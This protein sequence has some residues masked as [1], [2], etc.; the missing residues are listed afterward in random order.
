M[1]QLGEKSTTTQSNIMSA[2]LTLRQKLVDIAA[3]DVG[4]KE[5]TRNRAPH[6]AKYWPHTS[7][8]DGMANREPYCAAAVACWVHKW[9]ML[10]EVQKAL[11]LTPEKVE[12]FRC[13]SARAFDWDDWGKAKGLK[14]LNDSP[15]N[16]LRVG[17]IMI[18]D[19]S[20]IGIVT[21]TRGKNTVLTIEANT[22]DGND[23]DGVY[24]A[25]RVRA[26]SLA[27]AF[28]RIMPEEI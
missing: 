21:G 4:K 17:D 5:I 1:E 12:K 2:T 20:H 7:Y 8:P 13:K 23:R 24:V 9:L 22:S 3:R 10:P 16:K 28:V 25:K 18:F 15:D 26:R 27:L 19:M 14:I 11:K 6:I